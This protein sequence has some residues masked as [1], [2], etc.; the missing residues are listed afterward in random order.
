MRNGVFAMFAK[1]IDLQ[2]TSLQELIALVQQGTEILLTEDGIPIA[3]LLPV[4]EAPKKRTYSGYAPRYNLD[5]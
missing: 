1:Q 2:E 4:E 5:E 3:R